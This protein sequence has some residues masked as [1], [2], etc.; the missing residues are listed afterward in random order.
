MGLNEGN[1]VIVYTTNAEK[2]VK[3]LQQIGQFAGELLQIGSKLTLFSSEIV[4]EEL[5]ALPIS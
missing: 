4:R 2:H 1:R 3:Y 5:K